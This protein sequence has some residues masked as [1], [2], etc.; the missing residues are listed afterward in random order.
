MVLHGKL[1]GRVGRRRDYLKKPAPLERAFFICSVARDYSSSIQN[2]LFVL[3]YL[4]PDHALVLL[5]AQ[6]I[7][8]Q[9]RSITQSHC[10]KNPH[11]TV[12]ELWTRATTTRDESVEGT[13]SFK[14]GTFDALPCS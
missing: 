8:F 7:R 4:R 2:R 6:V 3:R 13:A 9:Q 10:N 12:S 1:C 5:S 11:H 14:I